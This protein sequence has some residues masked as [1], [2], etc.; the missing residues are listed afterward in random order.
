ASDEQGFEAQGGDNLRRARKKRENAS[1]RHTVSGRA[2]TRSCAA[3]S[4]S[5][6][7]NPSRET[8]S[9]RSTS[10]GRSNIG[11]AVTQVWN[12]PF[13]PQG[14]TSRGSASRKRASQ[15]SP[16]KKGE[17]RRGSTQTTVA[18]RPPASISFASRRVSRP[19][20]GKTGSTHD[21]ASSSSRHFLT[22][23]SNR[24]P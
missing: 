7:T 24:S 8:I 14:S 20:S 22:S 11:P 12:S 10:S 3:Y 15:D 17:S 1:R 4:R 23:S 18:R 21:P 13:S 5:A 2:A 9:P 19:Q 6:N 16:A